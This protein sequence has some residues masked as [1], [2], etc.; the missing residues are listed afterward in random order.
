[1]TILP[2]V[3][4][5]AQN[6]N[7]N[8]RQSVVGGIR[9]DASGMVQNVSI[10]DRQAEVSKVREQILGGVGAF[11]EAGKLRMVSLK[12][13]QAAML[14]SAKTGKPL[15]EEISLLGGLTRIEYV[16]A[17]P[18]S[19]D[20]VLAGPSENWTVGIDGTL[21][22]IESKQPVIYL[23]DFLVAFRSMAPDSQRTISCSIDPTAE[24][25]RN[26][27]RV[28]D[29]IPRN[30]NPVALEPA[31]KQAFGPQQISLTGV[32]ASSRV[33][34]ILVAA[35]YRMKSYGMNLVEAPVKGLPSYVELI[36][37]KSIKSPQNRWWMACDYKPIEQ[38]ADGLSWRISGPGIKTLTEQEAVAKDGTFKQSGKTDPSAVRW[39][40]LF[41]DKLNEISKHEPVF[42]MLRNVMDCSVASAL[43][44]SRELAAKT[45][46]DLS[47]LSGTTESLPLARLDT[48]K[49]LEPQCSF[50]KTAG[51]WIVT[52]SG[53]VL[54][55]GWKV[56]SETVTSSEVA[57]T[58]L[59]SAPTGN[60][61]SWK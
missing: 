50:L 2:S 56:A 19:N 35:D 60:D 26:L 20:I 27:Q 55:D 43:I 46:C 37:N 40:N 29:G 3:S 34:R 30:A 38:A 10:E 59:K 14:D 54:I 36:S 61:W 7:N 13:V 15:A 17:Y 39:A 21:V 47:V 33:A 24:G 6:N 4:L 42:G 58:R 12:G 51:G 53:G 22:G 25:A 52:A 18:E 48:P 41:T 23:E 8:G 9:I 45:G 44:H 49:T 28:L 11:A 1:L 57:A 32:D 5:F 31:M 16:L